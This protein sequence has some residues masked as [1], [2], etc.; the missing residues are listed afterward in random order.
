MNSERWKQIDD[1]LHSVLARPI[2]ERETFLRQACAGDQALEREIR[3]LLRS[4]DQAGSFL[5]GPAIEMAARD[6]AES[7]PPSETHSYKSL[8]AGQSVSRYRIAGKLGGGGMGVVYKADDTRLHRSVALK[9]LPD[10]VARDPQALSRFEREARAASALNHPNICAIYDI[11][12]HEGRT[13]LVMEYLEGATLKHCIAGRP[14]TTERLFALSIEIAEGLEAA[15]ARGIIH[16]DIKPANIFVTDR[17][18]AKVLDFGLAKL[19]VGATWR[20][21]QGGR[22]DASPLQDTPTASIEEE[23][24]TNTGMTVG[25]VEYMSPEQVRAEVLD[26]R[27]DLFS[28]GAVLYEMATGQRAFAGNS[29]GVTFE[30]ILNRA[31]APPLRLNPQLPPQLEEIILR[32]LEKNRDLRYRSA[33]DLL[34]DLRRLKGEMDSGRV[35][36]QAELDVAAASPAK[37]LEAKPAQGS[38][39]RVSRWAATP[40]RARIVV[41][42]S[43][44]LIAV[45]GAVALLIFL[46]PG[47]RALAL[48]EKDTLVLADFT[49]TTGDP[50]FD[51]TLRQGLAIQLEQSPFLSL[52][53]DDRI[54][55]TLRLMGQ[56]P[57]A[58]LIPQRAREICERTASA[59]VLEGS[60][61]SLGSQYVLG[62]SA[63]TCGSGQVLDEEQVQA[64]RKEDVLNALSQIASRFRTRVG[65]SLATIEKHDVPLYEATTPSLEA[66]KAY[67]AGMRASFTSG[68]ADAVPLHKRAVEIDP[69]FAMAHASLGLMYSSLGESVL[70]LESTRRAYQLRDHATDR[71]R[72]FITTLYERDV[73][74]NLEK[75]QRTLELWAQTYPR[76]RDAHGLMSGF[77]SQGMG[78][79]E[80]SLKEAT[81]ALGIDPDCSPCFVNIAAD[82]LCLDR[83]LE[84]EETA[85]RAF[86]RKFEVPEFMLLKFYLAF[87]KGDH[88]GMDQAAARAKGKPGA[89]DWMAHSEALVEARSG[90]LRAAAET[91]RQ[92]TDLAQRAGE[93]ERAATYE[94][95]KAVWQ[96][97]YGI[98]PAAKQSAVAALELSKG[99]DVE[100][101][102]AFAL[103]LAGDLSRAQALARD[104]EKRFPEDTSVQFNYLPALRA[105][106]ALNDRKPQE[107]IDLLQ[108]AA[109]YDFAVPAI[110]FNAFFGGLYPAY[111][112]GEAYLA[113]REP[114]KAAAEFQKILD[115]RGLVVADP[116]GAMARLQLGR[117]FALSGD[118]TKAKA[119][120]QDFLTL[121][122][123]ADPEIPIFKQAKAEYARLQ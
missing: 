48:T 106:F 121:W 40:Q 85:R 50:V 42:L 92:A 22:G 118:K 70:S 89:E 34:V 61:A 31:P 108:V 72:F 8:R 76:D 102:A 12:E 29:P 67:T 110:D 46:V 4:H 36:K 56:P 62:L 13:F 28:F 33:A 37:A 51:G 14:M 80:K 98:A 68:F 117:A 73:T 44:F 43:L 96:A 79:Y 25:T 26:Q 57:D 104:L 45:A 9:F 39:S 3:S 10:E 2:A 11:G 41:A 93:R 27:T 47:H 120:Y 100:Y 119:A 16:R 112:R 18:H 60:I 75:E 83:P 19:T 86:A 84:A 109:P 69:Q 123:E 122:K 95:G 114:A 38:A 17:G 7:D 20:V 49:N 23:A 53:P 113:V 88:A 94:A 63:K 101:G 77:A 105:L 52:V 111:V 21:A 116:V 91:S 97:F 66:L 103:A 58:P 54:R 35:A 1:L 81:T 90:H 87:L 74:G 82:Y 115:H 15:H 71:E 99:R 78:Q 5:E 55:R 24:L 65:E 59:A 30:A 64:P 32:L 6:M 107:A